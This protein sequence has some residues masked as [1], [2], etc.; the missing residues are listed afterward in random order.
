[1]GFLDPSRA[2]NVHGSWPLPIDLIFAT[3]ANPLIKG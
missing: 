3:T 2:A 1:L